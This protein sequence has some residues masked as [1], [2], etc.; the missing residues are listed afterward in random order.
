METTRD[1][2]SESCNFVGDNNNNNDITNISAGLC[3]H[4][5]QP[6]PCIKYTD[7][8]D[9]QPIEDTSTTDS[10]VLYCSTD[11]SAQI[12][13]HTDLTKQSACE[14]VTSLADDAECSVCIKSDQAVK[15]KSSVEKNVD[16]SCVH[17]DSNESATC[18]SS[19]H[20]V[21]C[22]HQLDTVH[23]TDDVQSCTTASEQCSPVTVEAVDSRLTFTV[24]TSADMTSHQNVLMS[25]LDL[26]SEVEC[27][28]TNV[29]TDS[30]QCKDLKQLCH[31][32][33]VT[34]L[35]NSTG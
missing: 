16:D 31:H 26:Q 3:C 29:I 4:L 27:T 30:C 7:G 1:M 28:N 14:T 25:Q 15:V 35:L 12:G 19:C 2:Y 22:A 13:S 17:N 8:H 10:D 33:Q 24:D 20:C 23:I 9:C 11:S 34:L 32:L 21:A 6:L 5:E 18:T